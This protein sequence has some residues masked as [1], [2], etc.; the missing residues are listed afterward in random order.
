MG[1]LLADRSLDDTAK[2]FKLWTCRVKLDS[3]GRQQI[4]HIDGKYSE[5]MGSEIP[6]IQYDSKEYSKLVELFKAL[7]IRQAGAL[8]NVISSQAAHKITVTLDSQWFYSLHLADFHV[9]FHD[10]KNN[11]FTDIVFPGEVW[12]PFQS[13]M[14]KLA[15]VLISACDCIGG[16]S[17][18][19]CSGSA[20]KITKVADFL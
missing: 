3:L 1:D 16:S 10:F 5:N 6:V 11:I 20:S 4:N 14:M 17:Q 2:V 9:S 7:G 15:E 18:C 19:S 13:I 8:D 12:H